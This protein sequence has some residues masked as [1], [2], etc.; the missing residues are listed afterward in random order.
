[1]GH[2]GRDELDTVSR[3]GPNGAPLESSEVPG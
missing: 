2:K 3:L 1:M